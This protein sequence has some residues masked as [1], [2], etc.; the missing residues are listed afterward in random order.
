ML[1][2]HWSQ[3][4]RWKILFRPTFTDRCKNSRRNT[5]VSQ[6]YCFTNWNL[7]LNTWKSRQRMYSQP[8]KKL[9]WLF[10]KTRLI[11]TT[12]QMCMFP[13]EKPE[14]TRF[15]SSADECKQ[16]RG[17]HMTTRG[18]FWVF[19]PDKLSTKSNS[20]S[21]RV[22]APQETTREE[23]LASFYVALQITSH[24]TERW[25]FYD[26]Q[27]RGTDCFSYFLSSLW[28]L[29]QTQLSDWRDQIRLRTNQRCLCMFTV[30]VLIK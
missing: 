28:P 23:A 13:N 7:F 14:E 27:P 30:S 2:K 8:K 12:A 26:A 18:A 22:W 4:H 9:N 11:Q 10:A 20:T 1:W 17:Q 3:T 21:G 15:E 25:N 29:A 19:F 24:R 6:P 5:A 16:L